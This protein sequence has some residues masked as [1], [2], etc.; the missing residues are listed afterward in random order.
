M[1]LMIRGKWMIRHLFYR[2]HFIPNYDCTFGT[3]SELFIW[4]QI[5]FY[6]IAHSRFSCRLANAA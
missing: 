1:K 2:N 6:R 3:V 4:Q 5:C